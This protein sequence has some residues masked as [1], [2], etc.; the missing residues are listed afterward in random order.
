M[1]VQILTNQQV[2]PILKRIAYQIVESNS[3]AKEIFL[4]HIEGQGKALADIIEKELLEITNQQII[5]TGIKID[6]TN[7][8]IETTQLNTALKPKSNAGLVIIDDVLNSGRTMMFA[9]TACIGLGFKQIQIAVLVDRSYKHFPIQA[10]F[11]GTSL[12]TTLQEH[13]NVQCRNGK[14]SVYVE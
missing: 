14:I 5:R 2:A 13:I 6:K 4:V 1:K 10:N 11:I 3:V 9:I 12:S 7:P 8:S